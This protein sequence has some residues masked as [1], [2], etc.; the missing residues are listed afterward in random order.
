M[1]TISL[2]MYSIIAALLDIQSFIN[3]MA[4][5]EQL[6]YWHILSY[7]IIKQEGS[8]FHLKG[9][10]FYLSKHKFYSAELVDQHFISHPY[11]PGALRI[12]WIPSC[13]CGNAGQDLLTISQY[14]PMTVF[15]INTI[16]I[17]PSLTSSDLIHFRAYVQ[18]EE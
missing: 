14:D 11:L 1:S 17:W 4:N 6:Q 15:Y 5:R 10:M 16:V 13:A 18:L 7:K 3:V 9:T 12:T 2:K 8:H